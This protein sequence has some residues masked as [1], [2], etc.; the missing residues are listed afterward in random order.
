VQTHA[1]EAADIQAMSTAQINALMSVTPI[2]LDLDHNGV[3]T[4][5]AANGVHFDVAGTGRAD[6]FGWV[7]GNDGL[8]V[9]DVNG[10]GQIDD[11]RELFGTGTVLADGHRAG[12]GF[13][14]LAALDSNH[15]GVVNAS[16]AHFNELKVWVDAN[17][18]GK[19]DPGELKGLVELGI[20]GLNLAAVAS[21]RVDH[22][23][24]VGLVSSYTTAD[25]Q[26]HEMADVW[27][28]RQMDA[29][30]ALDDVLS[31][32]AGDLLGGGGN[33]ATGSPASAAGAPLPRMTADD[34][35]LRNGQPLL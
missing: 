5:A 8:L 33:A 34:E 22:G 14:A 28:A 13:A 35:L 12:N 19:T 31:A 1:F 16:D 20:T 2:V 11:G 21:D 27:F 26:S 15:D 17:H 4:V 23:N 32:P 3:Q 9:R 6:R 18:D 29:A 24:A 10:N 30:P 7:G 25:G